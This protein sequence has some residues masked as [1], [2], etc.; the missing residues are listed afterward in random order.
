MGCCE[1]GWLFGVR[2]PYSLVRLFGV[3][4]YVCTRSLTHTRLLMQ[5]GVCYSH[6]FARLYACIE[7]P[8]MLS[9]YAYNIHVYIHLC[10]LCIQYAFSFGFMFMCLIVVA[11]S[12]AQLD[13]RGLAVCMHE[14]V[15]WCSSLSIAHSHLFELFFLFYSNLWIVLWCVGFWDNMKWMLSF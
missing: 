11:C 3:R 4:L 1:W 8:C 9:V 6:S 14:P 10:T 13:A 12:L 7:P 5:L 2:R 15:V